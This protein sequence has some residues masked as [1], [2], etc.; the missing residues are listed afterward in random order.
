MG[1]E[2][3]RGGAH[4]FATASAPDISA[5]ALATSEASAA[6]AVTP[7]TGDP[8]ERLTAVTRCPR[9][10]ASAAIRLPTIPVAPNSTIFM[11]PSETR[12]R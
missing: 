5:E 3:S 8:P 1:S 7:G 2:P 6:A 11:S 9:R 12:P 4:A 10:A